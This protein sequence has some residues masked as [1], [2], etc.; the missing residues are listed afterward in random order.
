MVKAFF[1]A[2]SIGAFFCLVSLEITD[3]F[4]KIMKFPSLAPL[5][6]ILASLAC[7]CTLHA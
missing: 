4:A 3:M 2:S 5:G 1:V 7:Q 6:A